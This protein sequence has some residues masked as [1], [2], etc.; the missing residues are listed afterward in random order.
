M[1]TEPTRPIPAQPP[2]RDEVPD[3]VI[4]EEPRPVVAAP[5]VTVRPTVVQVRGVHPV[6]LV[7]ALV[8]FAVLGALLV[9]L[10]TRDD[11][12]PAPTVTV[13]A[14]TPAQVVPVPVPPA[15]TV[16]V[17]G[18]PVQQPGPTVTVPGAAVPGPTVTVP[19]P[20][21]SVPAPASAP[22]TSPS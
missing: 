14:S 5:P 9:F 13:P 22:G 6:W 10:F 19:G 11:Q 18:P 7:L 3:T 16:T 17:P 12:A 2:R 8:A 20:T 4:L 21:V 1:T 15:A